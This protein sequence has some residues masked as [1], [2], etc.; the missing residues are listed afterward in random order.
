MSQNA[1]V[2]DPDHVDDVDDVLEQLARMHG[3]MSR[4]ERQKRRAIAAENDTHPRDP[5]LEMHGATDEPASALAGEV[6]LDGNGAQRD[7]RN[8]IEPEPHWAVLVRYTEL[9]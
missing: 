6:Q 1:Y 7:D 4:D 2:S 9:N 5:A 8:A 3:T